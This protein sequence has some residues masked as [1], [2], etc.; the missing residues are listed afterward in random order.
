M[1]WFWFPGGWRAGGGDAPRPPTADCSFSLEQMRRSGPDLWHRLS[2]DAELVAPATAAPTTSKRRVVTP[3]PAAPSAV[4]NF[5]DTEVFG[6]MVKDG[7]HSPKRSSDG[8]F[9]RRVTLDLT[10]E[11][12]APDTGNPF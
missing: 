1:R 12:A 2:Q 8:E 11:I 10:G 9:L 5:I 7:I 4:K 6:K 3:P